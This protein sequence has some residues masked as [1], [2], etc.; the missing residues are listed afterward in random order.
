M[1][2]YTPT[3]T[4]KEESWPNQLQSLGDENLDT[5]TDYFNVL[6]NMHKPV[7]LDQI[8]KV[9]PIKSHVISLPKWVPQ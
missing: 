1:L 9:K 3:N 8:T 5:L 7:T 2:H 6:E 4:D